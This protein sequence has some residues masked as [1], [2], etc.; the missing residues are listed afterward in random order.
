MVRCVRGGTSFYETDMTTPRL[1]Q[2][3][4]VAVYMYHTHCEYATEHNIQ[5]LLAHTYLNPINN[6]I[7]ILIQTSNMN[8]HYCLSHHKF[9]C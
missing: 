3:V 2:L 1:K 9:E 5:Y 7:I 6:I 8:I 4:I